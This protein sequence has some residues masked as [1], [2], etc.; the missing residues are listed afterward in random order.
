MSG[1]PPEMIERARQTSIL[2]VL[3]MLGIYTTKI[4]LSTVEWAGACPVC[5]G[6]DRFSVNTKKQVFNCRG[7]DKG[8]NP[9]DLV[10]HVGG[11]SFP[12]AVER[13]IGRRWWPSER[14][15]VFLAADLVKA[16]PEPSDEDRRNLA[17]AA[18][19]VSEMRPV[20]S[21][22]R[23]VA[24][25]RDVR[26]IDVSE[27]EDVLSRTDAIGWHPAVYFKG[28]RDDEPPHPLHGKK[29]GAIIGIMTDTVTARP[30]GAISR[31]YL[32]P[33]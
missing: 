12:E 11:C 21:E 30:T 28:L 19:I 8:G 24:Y 33:D 20:I 15:E 5:G 23:A 25:F 9:I 32:A 13:L 27:I 3:D 2:A 6:R 17:R 1:V 14:P 4:K 26:K 10:M 29:L 22:P 7:C 16:D 31:T 18:K